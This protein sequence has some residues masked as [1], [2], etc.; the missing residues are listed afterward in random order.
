MV[1]MARSIAALSTTS[2]IGSV[3]TITDALDAVIGQDDVGKQLTDRF[4]SMA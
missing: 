4:V 2:C 3:R 1:L